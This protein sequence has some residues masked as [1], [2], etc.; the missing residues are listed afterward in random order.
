MDTT[1]RTAPPNAAPAIGTANS[2]PAEAAPPSLAEVE[3][4]I[5]RLGREIGRS[6]SAEAVFGQPRTVDEHTIIPVARV[7]YGFGGG[8]SP[9]GR[10]GAARAAGPGHDPV[11]R[12]PPE[13]APSA[14]DGG[15]PGARPQAG[16]GGGGGV[17]AE[18]VAVIEFGPKGVRVVP[19]VD[20]NRLV[21]RAFTTAFGFAAVALMIRAFATRGRPAPHR[22]TRLRPPLAWTPPGA[23]VLRHI[24]GG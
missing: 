12:T 10:R 6:A 8:A 4:I 15:G 11:A 7:A 17:R 18:P 22:A 1:T 24:R 2:A 21:G 5:A 20:V 13:S 19:V 14:G 3:E 9:G 16:F 23:L